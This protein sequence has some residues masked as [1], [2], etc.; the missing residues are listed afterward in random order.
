M[1]TILKT[2]EDTKTG[3]IRRRAN[4]DAVANVLE[5]ERENIREL[6]A[7]VQQ[8]GDAVTL[9]QTFSASLRTD[10]VQKFEDLLTKGVRQVFQKDYKITIE[11]TD[12][13]NSVYADFFVTL[14]DGKK[15]NLANEGGGLR[16]FVGILQRILYIILEPSVPSRILFLDENLKALDSERSPIAFKFISELAIELGIQM[17]FVTHSH[18]AKA[19]IDTEGVSL[20]EISND[21]DQAT[22]KIIGGVNGRIVHDQGNGRGTGQAGANTASKP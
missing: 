18:A 22:A 2:F 14:P 7:K 13:A 21:G 1:N 6:E 16:D 11:F 8:L 20:L 10:I 19:M 5:S 17:V 4:R 15:V 3:L 12:S 9:M